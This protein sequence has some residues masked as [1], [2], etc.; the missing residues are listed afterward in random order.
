MGEQ[1][2]RLRLSRAL[3]MKRTFCCIVLN[4][5]FV[6]KATELLRRREMT[7]RAKRRHRADLFN[8]LVGHCKNFCWQIE[9][10]RFRSLKIDHE[11][12]LGC[13]HHW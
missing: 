4:V 13:L 5:R 9:A 7:Q 8:H 10:K 12:E 3:K 1:H 6:P 11:H 2:L